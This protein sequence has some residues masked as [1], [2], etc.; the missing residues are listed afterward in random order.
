[1]PATRP[2]SN[3]LR[4]IVAAPLLAAQSP[5]AATEEVEALRASFDRLDSVAWAVRQATEYSR[6][7]DG[8]TTSSLFLLHAA[9]SG[10]LWSCVERETGES[11]VKDKRVGYALYKEAEFDGRQA[12]Q[13][14]TSELLPN[15]RRR[16]ADPAMVPLP[17]GPKSMDLIGSVDG[18]PLFAGA[19]APTY[20]EAGKLVFGYVESDQRLADILADAVAAAENARADLPA[21]VAVAS[22]TP[23]GRYAVWLDPEHGFLP[24]RI[25][26]TKHHVDK[27]ANGTP[28]NQARRSKSG[29]IRPVT[30]LTEVRQVI[31]DIAFAE[32]NGSP[33]IAA[34]R[35][36]STSIY[37]DAQQ[38][39]VKHQ[40]SIQEFRSSAPSDF[41]PKVHIPDGASVR[42]ARDPNIKYV[43]RDGEIVTDTAPG[44]TRSVKGLAY[45][46]AKRGMTSYAL[47]ALNVLA[48]G[49]I[50]AWI[51]RRRLSAQ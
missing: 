17:D 20:F 24:R 15:Y 38:L 3:L 19:G 18:G 47:I 50:V 23:Y 12:I 32:F 14:N 8:A 16:L 6:R 1:M 27:L 48:I 25:E 10:K 22:G 29:S 35:D 28:L 9:R 34:L 30:E 2:L 49:A 31:D 43:W 11:L 21:C 33:V 51:V 26:V 42:V 46:P 45:K 40:F 39:I 5:A 13:A 37:S 44:A 36:T 7:P 4:V 41:S